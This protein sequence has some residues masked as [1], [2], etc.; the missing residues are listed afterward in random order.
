VPLQFCQQRLCHCADC[1]VG[2]A[3]PVLLLDPG[4]RLSSQLRFVDDVVWAQVLISLCAQEP[5]DAHR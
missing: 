3:P 2:L 5:Q 1:A 4:Q